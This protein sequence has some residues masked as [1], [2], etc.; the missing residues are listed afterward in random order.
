MRRLRSSGFSSAPRLEPEDD[1]F[2][3]RHE[4]EWFETARAFVVE[5]AEEAVDV[6]LAEEGFGDVVVAAFGGP[7]GAVVAAAH[8]GGDA[9]AVGAVRDGGVDLADVAEVVGI[10]VVLALRGVV[11]VGEAGVVEL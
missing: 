10:P 9:H 1:A 6:E 7:A 8:V 3:G 11:E 4:A 5:L 2:A